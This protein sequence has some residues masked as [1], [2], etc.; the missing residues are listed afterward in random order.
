MRKKSAPLR[1]Q[2]ERLEK[3]IHQWQE[4]LAQVEVL[5]SDSDIYQAQRKAELSTQL[6]LQA[7]LKENI[8]ENEMLWLELA[9]QIEDIMSSID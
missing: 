6:K 1:K 3:N 8:E 2:V 9:E 5:L 7:S 4:Q